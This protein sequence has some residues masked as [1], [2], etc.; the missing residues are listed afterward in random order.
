MNEPHLV[1]GTL[2]GS[3]RK[4][5]PT[6]VQAQTHILTY[7]LAEKQ[8]HHLGPHKMTAYFQMPVSRTPPAET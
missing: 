4:L 3:L 2:L 1:V 5:M 7:K 8:F 6:E